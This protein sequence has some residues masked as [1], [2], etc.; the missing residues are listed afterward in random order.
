MKQA[1]VLNKLL[2]VALASLL[3]HMINISQAEAKMKVGGSCLKVGQKSVVSGVSVVCA[4]TGKKTIWIPA[5]SNE[6]SI[7][8]ED[9]NSIWW[10]ASL[11]V[12]KFLSNKLTTLQEID[13]SELPA[14]AIGHVQLSL[15][16]PLVTLPYKQSRHLGSLVLVDTA[17][18]KTSAAAMVQ[19]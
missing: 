18:H 12:R 14:N 2:V 16:Q 5:K 7:T 4:R 1:T 9:R 13:A 10:Q 15:Q 11:N 6:M 8:A 19:N 17:S 3:P